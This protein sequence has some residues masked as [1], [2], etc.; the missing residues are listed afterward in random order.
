MSV[1]II[2]TEAVRWEQITSR[3][4][5]MSGLHRIHSVHGSFEKTMIM[6][7]LSL[8]D[9]Y[10]T[11]RGRSMRRGRAFSYFL[12]TVLRRRSGDL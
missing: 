10:W 1:S 11:C 3:L 9:R 5:A 6:R 2:M 8:A 4:A 12:P 7:W